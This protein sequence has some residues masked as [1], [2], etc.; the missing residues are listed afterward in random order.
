MAKDIRLSKEKKEDEKIRLE[1]LKREI[2][3]K[4]F[5]DSY[6]KKDCSSR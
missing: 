3:D 1:Q 2:E 4:K 5:I 6:L